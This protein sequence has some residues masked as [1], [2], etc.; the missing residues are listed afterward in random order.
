MSKQGLGN[1]ITDINLINSVKSDLTFDQSWA[2]SDMANLVLDFHSININAVP[3]LTLPVAVVTDPDGAG[4]GLVYEGGGYGD[5][6]FPA[7]GQDQA[8]IDQLLGIGPNT[9]SMT[10]AALPSPSSVTVSVTQRHRRLQP[11]QRH[12]GRAGRARLPHRRG[13]G[14]TRGR[15]RGGDLR[16][17]RLTQPRAPRLPPKRCPVRC[18]DR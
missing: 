15:R 4:G 16:L 14:H 13:R 5:V 7:Q 11:G 12:L 9:D 18:R 2:V 3:Q 6:E 10:G 17:L 8:A 1:P